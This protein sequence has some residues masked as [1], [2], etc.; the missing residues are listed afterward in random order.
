MLFSSVS[1][2]LLQSLVTIMFLLSMMIYYVRF[3]ARVIKHLQSRAAFRWC[4]VF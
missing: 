2:S 4:L 1:N 3:R